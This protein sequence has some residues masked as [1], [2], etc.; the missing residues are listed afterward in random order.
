MALNRM[1]LPTN[2]NKPRPGWSMRRWPRP[3]GTCFAGRLCEVGQFAITNGAMVP[4][5][6]PMIE[7]VLA[8]TLAS[9]RVGPL[10]VGD[11]PRFAAAIYRAA[12]DDGSCTASH[13]TEPPPNYTKMAKVELTAYAYQEASS[14]VLAN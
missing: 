1:S 2:S 14:L 8:D 11:E 12:I 13:S 7:Q 3:R 6:G 4:V 10:R 9:C 5:H